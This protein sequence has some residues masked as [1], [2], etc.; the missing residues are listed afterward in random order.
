M[1]GEPGLTIGEIS[2]QSGFADP[3]YFARLFRREY[4]LSPR[5]FRAKLSPPWRAAHGFT[6]SR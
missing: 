3:K 5:E 4:Q 6:C 2:R 1:I